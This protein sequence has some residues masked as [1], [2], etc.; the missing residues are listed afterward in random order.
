MSRSGRHKVSFTED[1]Y[2]K[3]MRVRVEMQA[4]SWDDFAEKVHRLLEDHRKV[5]RI[6]AGY[7]YLN[8]KDA[9]RELENL[10][11]T[12]SEKNEVLSFIKKLREIYA[13]NWRDVLLLL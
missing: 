11:L 2:W 10:P 5:L 6:L 8:T 4:H 13:E 9:D 7:I 12:E 3:V 1:A